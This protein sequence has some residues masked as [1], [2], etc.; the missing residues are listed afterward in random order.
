VD[1]IPTTP[2][3]KRRFFISEVIQG[4]PSQVGMTDPDGAEQ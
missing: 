4:T 1:E 3:G 2:A